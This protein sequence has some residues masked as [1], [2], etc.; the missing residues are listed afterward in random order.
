MRL[1]EAS[2][3][4]HVGSCPCQEEDLYGAGGGNSLMELEITASREKARIFD[5]RPQH[6]TFGL[7]DARIIASGSPERSTLLHRMV[8]R[9]AG[10]MPPLAT[11]LVDRDAA[12][13]L[14]QW[15]QSLTPEEEEQHR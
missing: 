1:Q 6:H 5:E 8:T 9:G 11:S 13:L 4:F 2:E 3:P 14:R 15:I 10:Q 7:A 12:Q